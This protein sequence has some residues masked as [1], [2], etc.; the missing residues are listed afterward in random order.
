M[1]SI[2]QVNARLKHLFEDDA[3]ELAHQVGMR[4]RTISFTQLALLLVLGWWSHP[5]SGPSALARF[6]GSLGLTLSKQTVDCHWSQRTAE[7]LLAL[8]QRAVQSVV[9]ADGTSMAWMDR[10]TAVWV[11][12]GSSVSLPE[13]LAA[14]WQGCGGS[15]TKEGK[16][17]KT[18]SSLKATLRLDLK[19]GAWQ[20]PYLQA[21]RRHELS[22]VLS[23]QPM[24]R[25]SLWLADLGYWSL[26]YMST[27]I[28]QGVYFCLRLKMAT[29]LWHEKQ[30]TDAATLIGGL[31]EQTTQAQWLVNVG[32]TQRVKGVRL[33]VKRV[34]DEVAE[35]R[36]ERIR[37]YARKHS[38]PVNSV[39]LDLAH[40]SILVTNLPASLVSLEQAF[41]LMKA[42]WQIELVFKLWKQQALVDEW[43]SENPWRILCEVYAKLL[44]MVVQHWVMLLACRDDPYASETEV[45]EI[46]REQVPMLVHGF[47]KHLTLG[48]A[49]RLVIESV[50]GGCSIVA[51]STR[52]STSRLI[53]SAFDLPLT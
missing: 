34:P 6:A 23:S 49:I 52:L 7:W 16:A 30:R 31:D 51:R 8:L 9:S 1:L 50:R 22:S 12:D 39:A 3:P 20:G 33:L 47:C 38:K 37:E 14:V 18:A 11:E 25:G 53:Q 17:S 48:K 32:E 13:A 4:E 35:Q 46:L 45:A 15:R 24:P 28:K 36:Q 41:V 29:V 21:G 19:G 26:K 44:A 42:R 40:W 5:K 43:T 10:F 27:L 2:T